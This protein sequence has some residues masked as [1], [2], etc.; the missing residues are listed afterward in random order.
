MMQFAVEVA[1]LN[2]P[3]PFPPDAVRVVATTPPMGTTAGLFV[4]VTAVVCA[5]NGLVTVSV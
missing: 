3:D 1:K 4:T 2:A 5:A